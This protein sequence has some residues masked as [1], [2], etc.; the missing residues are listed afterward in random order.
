[1]RGL[2]RALGSPSLLTQA[3]HITLVPPVNVREDDLDHAVAVLRAAAQRCARALDFRLGPVVTFSPVSP[4]LY[5]QVESDDETLGR[6]RRLHDD[7]FVGPLLRRVDFEYVPHVTV[8]E[9]ADQG[10]IDAALVALQEFHVTVCCERVQLLGQDPTDRA[11][12]P[13]ADYALSTPVVRGRGGVELHLRW[14]TTAAPDVIR[15]WSN[16]AEMNASTSE[17]TGPWL[18]ARDRFG[19]LLGVRQGFDAVVGDDHLGE[20]I[21]QQLLGEPAS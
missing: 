20:G 12:R 6:L 17:V 10:T 21:E 19:T 2:R 9:S 8:H 14:T 11:W 4:V 1:M 16:A 5:L 15:F 18:E 7:L 13:L 3:P